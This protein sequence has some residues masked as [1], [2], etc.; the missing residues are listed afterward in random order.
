MG[1]RSG[2][3]EHSRDSRSTLT[4]GFSGPKTPGLI[5]LEHEI[6]DQ[7]VQIFMDSLPVMQSNGWNLTSVA[8][9]GPTGSAYRNAIGQ[10][11]VTAANVV[12]I[13]DTTSTDGASK[14]T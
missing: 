9:L 1:H 13:A 4:T 10:G 8:Q 3:L 11:P 6:S 7:M 12:L 5:I 2:H 14:G